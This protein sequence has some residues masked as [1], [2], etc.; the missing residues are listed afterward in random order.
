MRI[1]AIGDIHG[2][3]RALL[4]LLDAV[5]PQPDDL[6]VTLGDYV[7]RGPDSR[8]V[9]DDLVALHAGGRLVALRG[10]HDQMMVDARDR[11]W[12]SALWLACGGLQTLSSY[13]IAL[14]EP[15]DLQEVPDAHWKFLEEDCRDWYETERHLFV[16]A[17]YDPDLA[18]PDQ[19]GYLLRW[20]KLLD[21]LPHVSGKTVVCGH[22]KQSKPLNLGHV[23]CIDTGVYAGGWLTCLDVDSGRIWQANEQGR[24]RTGWLDVI[25][26][27]HQ[28]R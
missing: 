4:A 2:C 5:S 9:L 16:H 22:T 27:S 11:P 3:H 6:L 15:L 23:V 1:L 12:E 14:A 19:P 21:P 20:E 26:E 25:D 17:S 10:N 7:D 24:Q 13:G 28:G 18:M 8:L